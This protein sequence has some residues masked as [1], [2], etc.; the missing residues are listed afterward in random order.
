MLFHGENPGRHE[1][2]ELPLGS[3]FP[4]ALLLGVLLAV[5]ISPSLLLDLIPGAVRMMVGQS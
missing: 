2:G 4:A 5:G 3:V 1:L